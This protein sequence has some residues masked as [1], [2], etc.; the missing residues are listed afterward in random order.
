MIDGSETKY[1]ATHFVDSGKEIITV[2]VREYHDEATGMPL[3]ACLRKS[4]FFL[5]S[6]MGIVSTHTDIPIAACQKTPYLRDNARQLMLYF[7]KIGMA[8]IFLDNA[9]QQNDHV[10]INNLFY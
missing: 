4:T 3:F 10:H 7:S 1:L 9:R 8:L 2:F 5:I 6:S